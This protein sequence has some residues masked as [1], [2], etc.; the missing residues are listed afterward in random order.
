VTFKARIK[1]RAPRD[2]MYFDRDHRV[3]IDLRAVPENNEANEDLIRFLARG[4]QIPKGAIDIAF[5]LKIRDKL[6][7]ISGYPPVYVTDRLVA[8]T[9]EK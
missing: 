4:L 7:R 9:A 6:V 3:H 5:G 1:P 2:R 8:M